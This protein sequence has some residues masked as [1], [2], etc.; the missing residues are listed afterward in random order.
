MGLSTV[1]AV[2]LAIGFASASE[3]DHRKKRED[4][5]KE[6][7]FT[8]WKPITLTVDWL[9]SETTTPVEVSKTTL[10]TQKC[11]IITLPPSTT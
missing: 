9:F 3:E 4:D 10:C 5:T 1:F 2:L 11:V 7:S 8:A 6:P